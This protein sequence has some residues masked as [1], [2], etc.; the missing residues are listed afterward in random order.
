MA[1]HP[2]VFSQDLGAGHHLKERKANNERGDSKVWGIRRGNLKFSDVILTSVPRGD[3][4][5]MSK[6][7]QSNGRSNLKMSQDHATRV[8]VI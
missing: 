8:T 4:R 7:V 3:R 6:L 1:V 5:S 2:E